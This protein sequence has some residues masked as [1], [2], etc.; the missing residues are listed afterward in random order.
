MPLVT[1]V[2]DTLQPGIASPVL[3]SSQLPQTC[4]GLAPRVSES[5]LRM[6]QGFYQGQNDQP[7]WSVN[8][9]LSA[10]KE[11]TQLA[12]DG[13]DPG[14]WLHIAGDLCADI[15]ISQQYLQAPCRTCT[16]V[17]CSSRGSSRY[18][19]PVRLHKTAERILAAHGRAWRT[20]PGF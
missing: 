4:P 14:T 9:R 5:M 3:G 20:T 2:A 15:G 7:V 12:D 13:L 1:A 6:L 19:M 18:G 8:G 16:M 10:R 17:A 11:S